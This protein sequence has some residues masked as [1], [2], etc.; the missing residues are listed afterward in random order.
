MG[1]TQRRTKFAR[2]RAVSCETRGILRRAFLVQAG[3]P[4]H[5]RS[6][7]VSLFPPRFCHDARGRI[8]RN[9]LIERTKTHFPH[10][11]TREKSLL[12]R[13]IQG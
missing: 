10:V 11:V 9:L 5:A 7:R 4:I 2:K 13:V 3:S 1:Y 12:D 6:R 8:W